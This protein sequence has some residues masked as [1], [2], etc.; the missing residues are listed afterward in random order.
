MM[1]DVCEECGGRVDRP[2]LFGCERSAHPKADLA[3]RIAAAIEADL[4][5]RSGLR[6][7]FEAIDTDMQYQIRDAWAALIRQELLI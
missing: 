5:D 3:Q 1:V 4:R 6:Q 2:G 7:E